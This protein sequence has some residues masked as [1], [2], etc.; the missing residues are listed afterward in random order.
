MQAY[1]DA[2]DLTVNY[3]DAMVHRAVIEQAKGIL[4]G[5]QRCTPDQAFAMLRDASQRENVKLR[6]IARRLV[7]NASSHQTAAP[8]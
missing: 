1:W 5:A 7:D 4:M 6:D 2:H 3:R 8:D